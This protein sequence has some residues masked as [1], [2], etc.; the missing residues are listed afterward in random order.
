MIGF[1]RRLK[2]RPFERITHTLICR[3]AATPFSF[4][5]KEKSG[6]QEPR[7]KAT[8]THQHRFTN[9][10]DKHAPKIIQRCP[11]KLQQIL[12]RNDPS[13]F[14]SNATTQLHPNHV[15]RTAFQVDGRATCDQFFLT[16]RG[17]S[18]ADFI[19]EGEDSALLGP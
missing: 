15:Y 6:A 7:G 1:T 13:L 5:P 4:V 8:A 18:G 11:K 17:K 16:C 2:L 9:V 3:E 14:S 12:R 10:D 19:F